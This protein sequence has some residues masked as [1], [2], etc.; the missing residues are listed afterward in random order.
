MMRAIV[1]ALALTAISTSALAQQTFR[2]RAGEH[3]NY[4]RL[5][6]PMPSDLAWEFTRTN[7]S[8][9]LFVPSEQADFD[10][11]EVFDRIPRS[12][13]LSLKS[14]A[15]PGG[16]SLRLSLACDCDVNADISGQYLIID[17]LDAADDDGQNDL[18]ETAEQ[19]ENAEQE[20]DASAVK[21]PVSRPPPPNP[22][23]NVGE[24]GDADV[25]DTSNNRVDAAET[26][27]D[28]VAERLISQ[29]E[30]AAQQ[31]LVDLEPP[32]QVPPEMA[33]APMPEPEPSESSAPTLEPGEAD[34]DGLA[35]LANRMQ[36]ALEDLAS[37]DF[38]GGVRVRTPDEIF[39]A[40]KPSRG[41]ARPQPAK[42]PEVPDHC[43]GDYAFDM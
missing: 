8:A 4:S 1:L 34:I 12:R 21:K 9:E 13:L 10:F 38:G 30:K 42:E 15:G 29:L 35:D 17:V 7:R 37:A 36:R 20:P 5:V 31:G 3:A 23:A 2:V 41:V 27:A 16:V 40:P 43:I 24:G 19:A 6:I 22:I 14:S 39:E 26:S 25:A 18:A 11:A 28:A 32:T 33:K